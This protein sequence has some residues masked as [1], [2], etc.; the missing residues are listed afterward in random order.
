[1]S[2]QDC[3]SAMIVSMP[4]TSGMPDQE[5]FE[6]IIEIRRERPDIGIIAISGGFRQGNL[7]ILPM[8]KALG[9]NAAIGKPFNPS[10]LL[11][12]MERLKVAREQCKQA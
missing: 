5:G 6:T 10:Q 7:N 2:G 11:E 3:R 12:E 9:A 1:M 8:A 4:S